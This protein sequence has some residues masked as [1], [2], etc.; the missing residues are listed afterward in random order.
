MKNIFVSESMMRCGHPVLYSYELLV[1]IQRIE[2][3]VLF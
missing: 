2:A 3:D 1:K